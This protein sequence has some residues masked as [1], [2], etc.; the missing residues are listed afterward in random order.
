MLF[1]KRVDCILHCLEPLPSFSLTTAHIGDVRIKAIWFDF[2]SFSHSWNK[3]LYAWVKFSHQVCFY[4]S[5][6]SRRKWRTPLSG[7]VLCVRKGYEWGLRDVYYDHENPATNAF[8]IKKNRS[9]TEICTHKEDKAS[10]ILV[11]LQPFSAE[12]HQRPG[13]EM[14]SSSHLFNLIIRLITRPSSWKNVNELKM[15]KCTFT[16]L[17]IDLYT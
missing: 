13:I 3:S 16:F 11:I 1:V 9:E 4:K 5:H 14:F 10:M 8:K 2:D 15:L 6:L 12:T 17:H 7:Q